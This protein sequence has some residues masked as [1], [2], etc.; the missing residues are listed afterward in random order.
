MNWEIGNEEVKKNKES[1]PLTLAAIRHHLSR[2]HYET[3]VSTFK[4]ATAALHESNIK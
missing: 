4:I 3:T 2:E 1:V